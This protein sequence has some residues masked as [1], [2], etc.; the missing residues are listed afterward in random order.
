MI[1]DENAG[2]VSICF[3]VLAYNNS[4]S[5]LRE[6]FSSLMA[7]ARLAGVEAKCIL[8][9]NDDYFDHRELTGIEVYSGQGNIGFAAGIKL[10]MAKVDT[11]Y[12]VLAN[13]DIRISPRDACQFISVLAAQS[14]VLVPVLRYV[15][16]R[17]AYT[18]YEDWIF[19]AGRKVSAQ[20]CRWF[21][22]HSDRDTLPPR[23]RICGAFVGMPTA[24]A[25]RFGPFDDA[26]FMYGE[27]RDLTK[28]LRADKVSV[29]LAR[30]VSVTHIGG[31]SG[32]GM[33][34]EIAVFQADGAMRIA[35]R[36][37]GKLGSWLK[38]VDLW[39]DA[40]RKTGHARSCALEARRV[41]IDHWRASEGEAP[42]LDL[43]SITLR[44]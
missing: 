3:L 14:G 38:R 20:V 37:Y 36:R 21:L 2:P 5:E 13:P 41:V 34:R 4:I 15:S 39:L 16:G 25:K 6:V 22:L 7:G 8:V 40:M 19:V 28:R 1:R 33:S 29:R 12:V 17:V 31:I 30:D 18:A 43:M 26:F 10:G 44:S 11:D 23:V 35:F 9:S 27:D 42:R 32:I 24:L